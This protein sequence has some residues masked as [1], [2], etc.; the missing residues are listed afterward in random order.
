MPLHVTTSG[1]TSSSIPNVPTSTTS[2]GLHFPMS[3]TE[4]IGS[5]AYTRPEPATYHL[6]SAS[7][8]FILNRRESIDAVIQAEL[9]A[10]RDE[11]DEDEE[12]DDIGPEVYYARQNLPNYLQQKAAS[13]ACNGGVMTP[14]GKPRHGPLKQHPHQQDTA[15][16]GLQQANLL[17]PPTSP[18]VAHN[19]RPAAAAQQ[20]QQYGTAATGVIPQQPALLPQLLAA[21][22][23][24][25]TSVAFNQRLS[26]SSHG[27]TSP[28]AHHVRT[29]PNH[30][31]HQLSTSSGGG[32]SPT[33]FSNSGPLAT[34]GQGGQNSNMPPTPA[35]TLSHLML[36]QIKVINLLR[37]P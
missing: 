26:S 29:P 32:G 22:P 5:G 36:S 4:F 10:D 15:A 14:F 9:A 2:G 28:Q 7:P 33:H 19:S 1:M 30:H 23:L 16:S 20:P 25:A 27:R 8:A 18:L 11:E 37:K 13:S 17:Q 12:Y 35:A 24:S 34:S 3:A 6:T 31:H 21:A